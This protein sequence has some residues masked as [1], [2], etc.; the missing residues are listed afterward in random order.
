MTTTNYIIKMLKLKFWLQLSLINLLIVALLG[1]VM[2]YKI[3]FEFPFL[4]QKHLQH[5]HSHFAFAAW[6]SQTLY[7]LIIYQ[8]QAHLS[9]QNIQ[10]Y[11]LL[12]II[13]TLSAWGMLIAFILQGYGAFSIAFS[14]LNTFV[15]YIFV[16]VYFKD[17]RHLPK[18]QSIQ[19]FKAGLIFNAVSSIGTYVLAY[20]MVSKTIVQSLYLSSVY[21]FLHFQY[22]AWFLFACI[23][24]LIGGIQHDKSDFKLPKSVFILFACSVI[25]AYLLS[26]LWLPLPS[27]LYLII[28]GAAL[29][30][31]LAWQ[32]LLRSVYHFFKQHTERFLPYIKFVLTLIAIAYSSK[33][34]LQLGS[35]VPEISKLAFGFRPIV[36]AYL[37]LILLAVI[38][39]FLLTYIWAFAVPQNSRSAKVYFLLV[40]VGIYLNEIVL[41]IQGIASFSYTLIPYINHILLII[42]VFIAIALIGLN[43]TFKKSN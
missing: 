1:V 16:F 6:I 14:Q 39:M 36:I 29:A 4:D 5:G 17:V 26:V 8:L 31:L 27:W 37:H 34:L 13:N 18:V 9:L 38:S 22:N 24:L 7:V 32:K 33:L 23:G 42:A 2:R 25:P 20:M 11:K 15:S 3:G 41:G 30:Q 12:L 21:F 43:L 35:T 10:R 19:W 40:A 28:V